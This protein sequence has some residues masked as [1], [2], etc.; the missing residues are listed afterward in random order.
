MRKLFA[1]NLISRLG[2]FVLLASVLPLLLVGVI[3]YNVSRTVIEREVTSYSQALVNQQADYLD[4]ILHQLS[5]L[6]ANV[7]GVDAIRDA[8]QSEYDPDDYFTRL[9]TNTEIGNILNR[10]STCKAPGW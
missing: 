1:P 9:S 4:L 3:T 6:L 8:L 2:I 10:L 5:A 7:S